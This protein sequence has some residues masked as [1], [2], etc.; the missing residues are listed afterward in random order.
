MD[1]PAAEI[2]YLNQVGRRLREVFRRNLVGFYAT[3]SL[4]LDGYRPG[5]SDFDIIAVADGPNAE[6]ID[7]VIEYLD[8]DE[9]PCPATGLEF[10]LYDRTVLAGL[11]IED[12]FALNF[13]TGR[14][15]PRL[16]EVGPQGRPG[17]WY[18][19]DR[20]VVH[21]R[22][23]Y[24]SF[25]RPFG[26]LS[27]RVPYERLLPVVVTS[28]EAHR[29]SGAELGDNSVLNAC[30]ALRYHALASWTA[31]PQAGAWARD[32]FPRF[33][34]VIDEALG[35]HLRDRAAGDDGDP[36]KIQE[37]LDFVIATIRFPSR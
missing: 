1:L 29:D 32:R 24:Y 7:E 2:N 15:L 3:G 16:V 26:E 19:I 18:P 27:T 33:A 21:Q 4:A 13:N 11:T 6:E 12:G 5:R 31:K 23:P 37:F 14:E 9:L 34:P 28:I 22:L 35:S 8:H 30:R 17:F 10:V 20:D 25:G 36:V